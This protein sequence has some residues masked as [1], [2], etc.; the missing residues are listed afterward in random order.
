MFSCKIKF[1]RFTMVNF[2]STEAYFELEMQQLS[3]GRSYGK[4]SRLGPFCKYSCDPNVLK[5]P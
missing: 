5:K 3:V 1:V 4:R 2:L